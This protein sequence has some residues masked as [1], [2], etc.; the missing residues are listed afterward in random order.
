MGQSPDESVIAYSTRLNGQVDVCDMFVTCP[1]WSTDIPYKEEQILYQ[2][3]RGLSDSSIQEKIMEQLL[4][5]ILES[6]LG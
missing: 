5:W 3:V 2:F 6:Y 1:E 4:R